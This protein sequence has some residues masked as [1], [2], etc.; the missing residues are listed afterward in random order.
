MRY[1]AKGR[2][3]LLA[4]EPDV[5]GVFNK[6]FLDDYRNW[7]Q[8]ARS[9]TSTCTYGRTASTSTPAPKQERRVMLVVIG[10]DTESGKDLLAIGRCVR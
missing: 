7:S 10:V 9:P 6:Q 8:P 1:W 4:F 3:T 2:N 5:K